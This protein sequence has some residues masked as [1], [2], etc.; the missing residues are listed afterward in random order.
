MSAQPATDTP[1]ASP[2]ANRADPL[3]VPQPLS[4]FVRGVLTVHFEGGAVVS[5]ATSQ[6]DARDFLSKQKGAEGNDHLTWESAHWFSWAEERVVFTSFDTE[7]D[8]NWELTPDERRRLSKAGHEHG[9][10]ASLV[11]LWGATGRADEPAYSLRAIVTLNQM[12]LDGSSRMAW[13]AS[14]RLLEG[15]NGADRV[16][17]AWEKAGAQPDGSI[18]ADDGAEPDSAVSAQER[19]PDEPENNDS[20]SASPPP[21]AGE[22]SDTAEEDGRS[23]DAPRA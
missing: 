13:E 20:A 19:E 3:D 12:A 1:D 8:Q 17:Q 11:T 10:V 21:A 7:T 22:D 16:A 4:A 14:A 18:V 6:W 5:R 15:A 2:N 23:S 9:V